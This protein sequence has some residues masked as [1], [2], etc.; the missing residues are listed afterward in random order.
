MD[1]IEVELARVV[2]QEKGDSQYIHL[3]DRSNGRTFT[4][5]IGWN[6]A[7]EINR[8]LCDQQTQRPLTHDL[9]GRILATVGWRLARV[10]VNELRDNTF[11]AVLVLVDPDGVEKT[12][13]CR[14]SDAIALAVQFKAALFVAKEILD[15]VS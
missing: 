12:V 13:D 10:I 6:E 5:V 11:F 15:Q 3:R 4:I 7:A 9:I 14:P 1:L 2:L 8:K